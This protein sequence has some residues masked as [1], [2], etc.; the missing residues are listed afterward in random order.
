MLD[1]Y[2]SEQ[3]HCLT[4]NSVLLKKSI[5]PTKYDKSVFS[6]GE[7]KLLIFEKNFSPKGLS[8]VSDL[9]KQ[10]MS[11]DHQAL[12]MYVPLWVI[13]NLSLNLGITD[14][15]KSGVWVF[16]MYFSVI[17]LNVIQSLPF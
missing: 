15:I 14:I 1:Q 9:L 4:E 16:Y 13:N 12:S 5:V 17:S 11:Q 10:I 3:E 6:L 2:L 7:K 8:L